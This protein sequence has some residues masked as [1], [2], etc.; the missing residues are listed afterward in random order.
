MQAGRIAGSNAGV[1]RVI[2]VHAGTSCAGSRARRDELC[3]AAGDQLNPLK[4]RIRIPGWL[5]RGLADPVNMIPAGAP[6]KLSG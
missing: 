2:V 6:A 1:V 3:C 4:L 5:R